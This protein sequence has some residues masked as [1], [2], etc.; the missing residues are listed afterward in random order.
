MH[1]G[2][3]AGRAARLAADHALGA[4]ADGGL[5]LRRII[6]ET[7][8]DNEASNRVLAGAGFTTW[9][10]EEAADAPDGSIG[11]AVHWERLA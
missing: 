7:A 9:G 5:G 2:V 11:P 6:A 10:R 3:V 4:V 1:V 8:A